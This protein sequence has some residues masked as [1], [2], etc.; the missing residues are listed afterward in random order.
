M[1]RALP[2]IVLVGETGMHGAACF[3]AHRRRAPPERRITPH[4]LRDPAD[5]QELI[6][7]QQ[8]PR[9]FAERLNE[10]VRAKYIELWSA[11]MNAPAE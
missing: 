7:I 5:V 9:E 11:V 2:L 10:F 6:R 1:R 3:R 4:R 8:L